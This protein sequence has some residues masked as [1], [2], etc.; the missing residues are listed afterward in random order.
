MFERNDDS[1]VSNTFKASR[2]TF[3]SSVVAAGLGASLG[4]G[5]VGAEADRSQEITPEMV[6]DF[7][8]PNLPENIA[9]D[10]QGNVYLSMA[11][12]GEIAR[13]SPDGGHSTVATLPLGENDD[14]LQL[15]LGLTVGNDGD[16][17]A[18]LGSNDPDTHGVWR[19]PPD[20][21]SPEQVASLPA[22]ET[23]PNG[24]ITAD[25]VEDG[26]LLAADH[27][28]GAVW[29]ITDSGAEVWVESPLLDPN[30][31]ASIPI[32]ADGLVVAPNGDLFVDNLN[33]GGIV[34]VPIQSDGSS[35]EPEV[36]VQKD[37]L[38]GLDG[39]TADTK[40]NLYAT[41]NLKNRVV[42]ITQDEQV[43]T[44]TS[45]GDLDF[46][47]DVHFGNTDETQSTLY[48]TNFAWLN[49]RADPESGSPSLMKLDLGSGVTGVK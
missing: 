40:G 31:Y 33:F 4:T 20:G 34:R 44:L 47:S 8:P 13:V 39:M 16:V 19:V 35:G 49:Y 26:A 1:N 41:V 11:V 38:V 15:L 36:F 45:G 6:A 5:T 9:I 30:P 10:G 18:A 14:E 43:E 25:E 17:Y 2:R 24:I 28:R 12:T 42:R 27:R 29:K 32:G 22:G 7:A 48:F 23:F 3:V 37:S 21:D 46:P